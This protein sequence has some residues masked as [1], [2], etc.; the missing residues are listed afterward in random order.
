M[1]AIFMPAI[2]LGITGIIMGVFLA[3]ASK[4]FEIQRDPKIEAIVSILPGVNCGGC[5][6]PGCMGYA[7]GVV[8]EGAKVNLCAPGGAKVLAAISDIMGVAAPVVE[9]KKLV[10]TPIY[11]E[12]FFKKNNRMLEVYKQALEAKDEEK[13]KKLE[14]AAEKTKKHDLE[15]AYKD[16]KEGKELKLV[17]REEI[18]KDIYK[19]NARML[20]AFSDAFKANDTEKMDKLIAAAEKTAKGDLLNLYEKI[21]AGTELNALPGAPVSSEKPKTEETTVKNEV[22]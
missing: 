19:K 13:L 6:Y 1:E 10:Y 7:I 12:T 20:G 4:K 22:N 11:D 17:N 5:G 16:L 3:Y 21:K 9:K 15:Q 14:D 2:I 8:E 18:E